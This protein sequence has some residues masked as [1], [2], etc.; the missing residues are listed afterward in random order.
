M[1]NELQAP[2]ALSPRNRSHAIEVLRYKPEGRGFD[3]RWCHKNFWLKFTFT[4]FLLHYGPGVDT[5]KGGRWVE[6]TTLPPSCADCLQVW[7]P[8]PPGTLWACNRPE[9]APDPIQRFREIERS[10]SCLENQTSVQ[11]S[12]CTDWNILANFTK[13]K[14]KS[15]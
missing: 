13:R 14:H 6:L 15:V 2:A 1:I 11:P 9:L 10:H 4:S 3:S 5:G 12:P 7:K 8:Q